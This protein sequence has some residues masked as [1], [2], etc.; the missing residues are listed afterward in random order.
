MKNEKKCLINESKKQALIFNIMNWCNFIKEFLKISKIFSQCKK[1]N[2]KI[3]NLKSAILI[4]RENLKT[5]SEV[6]NYEFIKKTK[7]F[8]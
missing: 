4:D 1:C 5:Q 7:L 3:W 6:K 2:R 8:T